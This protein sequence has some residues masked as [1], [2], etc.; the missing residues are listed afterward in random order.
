VFV[1]AGKRDAGPNSSVHEKVVA[2]RERRLKVTKEAAVAVGQCA[3]KRRRKLAL[4]RLIRTYR[5]CHA[6]RYQCHET[7]ETFP[8]AECCRLPQEIRNVGFVVALEAHHSM[9]VASPNQEIQYSSG[10]WS[11]VDVVT[12]Q[13]L[14]DPARRIRRNVGVNACKALCQKISATMHVSDRVNANAIGHPWS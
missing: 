13:Y 5:R 3:I 7:S 11:A 14:D 10:L 9:L 6:V 2:A 1:L 12:Q 4:L 8:L